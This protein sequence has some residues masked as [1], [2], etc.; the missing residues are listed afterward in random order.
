MSHPVRVVV[1]VALLVGALLFLQLRSRGEAVPLRKSFDTFPMAVAEW[2]GREATIFD[3]DVLNVLKVKDY[4]M[5]R[6][7]D[8]G[9]RSLWLYIGYWDTQRKGAQPHS[10]RNCLPGS[11]WEPVEAS[12]MTIPLAAPHGPITVNRFLI[13]KDREQQLLLYWYQSQGSVIAS[14]LS[15][16]IFMVKNAILR[17]RTDASIVRVSSPI[18]GTVPATSD[19]LVRYVQAMY[20]VLNEYLPD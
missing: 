12:L 10:P 13:Q 19:R 14:E 20:P 7:V 3:S 5:R 16:K 6:Y 8:D 15:G 18:Y 9:G 2:R 1:S 17:N 4:L 11:G